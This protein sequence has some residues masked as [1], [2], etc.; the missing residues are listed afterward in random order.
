[1][2]AI[3]VGASSPITRPGMVKLNARSDSPWHAVYVSVLVM[4]LGLAWLAVAAL[5]CERRTLCT[6]VPP[7]GSPSAQPRRAP[8]HTS[9]A[10]L[11]LKSNSLENMVRAITYDGNVKNAKPWKVIKQQVA[12]CIPNM[13]E[14]LTYNTNDPPGDRP[15]SE[16]KWEWKRSTGCIPWM[17]KIAHCQPQI[18]SLRDLLRVRI[19]LREN[20]S[21]KQK[22]K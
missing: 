21:E 4:G 17:P 7:P 14:A 20:K 9:R 3:V 19:V 5:V 13:L 6:R 1:M 8:R 10:H 18:R 22:S 11:N 15:I 12:S 16:S 2:A